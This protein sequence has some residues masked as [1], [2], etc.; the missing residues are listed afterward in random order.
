MMRERFRQ[1]F[2]EDALSAS[3]AVVLLL[4]GGL[5]LYGATAVDG[6]GFA[7][8]LLAFGALNMGAVLAVLLGSRRIRG[9]VAWSWGLLKVFLVFLTFAAGIFLAPA[10]LLWML[11]AVRSGSPSQVTVGAA[12][13][14]GRER[15]LGD[16]AVRGRDVAGRQTAA[17]RP[18]T[19]GA[20]FEA[21]RSQRSGRSRTV[22][23]PRGAL[24]ITRAQRRT[25]AAVASSPRTPPS[26][27]RWRGGT[28][29]T[30]I[31]S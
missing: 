4:F 6:R 24:G 25:D 20:N 16:R 10:A 27:R 23:K 22:C 31:S 19:T 12:S 3:L 26:K 29:S 21:G 30:T 15:R 8:I 14:G 28:P 13:A 17:R 1:S 5:P 9:A 18:F 7:W 11:L 2:R